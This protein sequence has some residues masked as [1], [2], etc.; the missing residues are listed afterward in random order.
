MAGKEWLELFAREMRMAPRGRKA[1]NV[2]HGANA[3]VSQK[4]NELVG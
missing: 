1:A 3:V 4:L 2:G